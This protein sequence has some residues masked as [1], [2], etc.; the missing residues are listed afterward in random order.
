MIHYYAHKSPLD[1]PPLDIK[2]RSCCA[3]PSTAKCCW[4]AIKWAEEQESSY[5]TVTW[6]IS[7]YEHCWK[8]NLDNDILKF[9]YR[10]CAFVCVSIYCCFV[11]IWCGFIEISS[12][13]HSS[14]FF[15]F[16]SY[17]NVYCCRR[18]VPG[19]ESTVMVLYHWCFPSNMEFVSVYALILG[20]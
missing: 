18:R 2:W 17:I 5:F 4:L 19:R 7:W 15:F 11:L 1:F 12:R 16:Q 3:F 14:L 20:N 9:D 8:C 10:K 6:W 13:W